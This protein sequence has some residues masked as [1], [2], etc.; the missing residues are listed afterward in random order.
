MIHKAQH[1][2]Y[3]SNDGQYNYQHFFAI[4]NLEMNI[5]R[6]SE[7]FKLGDCMVE[8]CV[9]LIIKDKS[10]ILSYSLLDTQSIISEYDINYINNNIKWYKN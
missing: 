8:F 2:T 4:F 7:L 6:Y 5:V 1:S 9:G 3:H 10:I